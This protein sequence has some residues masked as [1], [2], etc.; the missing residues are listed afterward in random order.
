MKKALIISFLLLICGGMVMFMPLVNKSQASEQYLRIH[1]RANSNLECDQDVK[2]LVKDEVVKYLTPKL[3]EAKTIE[4]A[5]VML[6][7][8]LN[9]LSSLASEKLKS[10]GYDY[11]AKAKL[12]T[13]YF[14]TRSYE[15]LTLESGYYDALIIELGSAEGNN[16]WCVVYP[17]LCF[18]TEG[19][20]K[21]VYKSYIKEIVDKIRREQWKNFLEFL[22]YV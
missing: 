4:N 19:E 13:E 11:S 16:W 3:T 6:Q 21:V 17:P 18:S 5:K 10:E 1:I 20:G 9:A 15:E 2:Y 12:A 14:P 22:P 7:Q 8:N